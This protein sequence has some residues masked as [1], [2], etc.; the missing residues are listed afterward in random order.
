MNSRKMKRF[1]IIPLVI[2]ISIFFTRL[3]SADPLDNWHVRAPS[4]TN[5]DLLSVAYGNG[6][7]VAVGY[8]GT[9]L[10]SPDGINWTNRTLPSHTETPNLYGITYGDGMFVAVGYFQD[11][12]GYGHGVILRSADGKA[13]TTQFSVPAGLNSVTYGNG[14]FI[15]AG[16]GEIVSSQD[17]S[18]WRYK[19]IEAGIDYITFENGVF[20][21][22]GYLL[23]PYADYYTGTSVDGINWDIHRGSSF[24]GITY[25]RGLFLAV[26][27]V[28]CMIWCLGIIASSPDMVQWTE[29][30]SFPLSPTAIT[31]GIGSFVAVGADENHRESPIAISSDGVTWKQ[32]SVPIVG[33]LTAVTHNGNTFVAVGENGTILQSDPA[34]IAPHITANNSNGHATVNEGDPLSVSV[35][36]DAGAGSGFDADWWLGA[37]TPTGWYYY[38]YPDQWLYAA[39]LADVLPA[40]QGPLSDQSPLEVLNIS[41]LPTGTYTVYFG[42]DTDRNGII[43]FDRLYLDNIVI[44]V[45]GR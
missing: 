45:V 8:G 39:D 10:T 7:F 32:I 6:L 40:Y 35:S 24:R 11:D 14:Y 3:S 29:R 12:F 4:L 42:V 27:P 36:L 1:I 22:L 31:Y 16:Y 20:L 19:A 9:I 26:E 25:G 30:V 17:G 15:A 38:L 37:Y 18:N 23:S 44:D 5:N 13:W 33:F 2:C 21:A 28:G 34:N 43:D 41:Q